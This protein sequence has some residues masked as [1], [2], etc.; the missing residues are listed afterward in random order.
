MILILFVLNIYYSIYIVQDFILFLEE[1][2]REAKR[3][4][5]EFM[6]DSC[7]YGLKFSLKATLEI[8]SFLTEKCCF[9]YLMTA[10]LNQD[11]LEV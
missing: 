7:C 6:S 2:K 4:S 3:K 11:N 9:S 5:L 1:W 8:C 10:R